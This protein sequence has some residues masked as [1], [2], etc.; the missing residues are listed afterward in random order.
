MH[1]AREGRER[2]SLPDAAGLGRPGHLFSPLV[3]IINT[4]TIL[5]EDVGDPTDWDTKLEE[6]IKRVGLA[7]TPYILSKQKI[8]RLNT[9][10]SLLNDYNLG[11]YFL[12]IYNQTNKIL[13]CGFDIL[14]APSSVSTRYIVVDNSIGNITLKLW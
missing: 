3:T 9:T 7:T 13:L 1:S 8:N 10:C 5:L 2:W 12:E 14:E 11:A 6:E 4:L